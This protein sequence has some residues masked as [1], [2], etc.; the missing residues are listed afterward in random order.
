MKILMRLHLILL[1]GFILS[2]APS[3]AAAAPMGEDFVLANEYIA[4]TVNGSG[5]NT[6]RFSVNTTGGDPLRSDDDNKPLIYGRTNPWTSFTTVRVDSRDY[7]FGG[8]TFKR[9][10][11]GVPVGDRVKGPELVGDTIV[12]TYEMDRV[13]VTQTLGF[14]RSLTTG[15]KDTARI[16]YVIANRGNVERRVGLRV[17]LDT[18][19][20]ANDGAPFR[21]QEQSV[22]SDLS[23]LGQEVPQFWQAFDSLS[24][25]Q[26]TAQGTLKGNEL[27]PPDRIFFTNWGSVADAPWD[28]DFIP[29]RDFTRA[30]EFEL[31]SA[32]AL[33]WEPVTVGPGQ[34]VTY[35]SHYGMGGI[36]IAPGKL[37]LGV[38]APAQVVARTE[39]PEE[40]S[41]IAYVENSGEGKAL[42]V[43]AIIT[44]PNG[45]ELV[46]GSSVKT[47]GDIEVNA[48]A[49][50]RWQVR[51]VQPKIGMTEIGVQVEA[52][53]SESN[54]V[55]RRLEV[56]APARLV[57]DVE[58][59]EVPIN[60]TTWAPGAFKVKTRITNTGGA[61][62]RKVTAAFQSPIGIA[63]A[64]GEAERKFA[65]DL[66]P[67]QTEVVAWNLVPT[68]V[69]GNAI[70]Y[71]I[72]TV[73]TDTKDT[74]VN[75]TVA[76]PPSQSAIWWEWLTEP[77]A[78][79]TGNVL[80]GQLQVANLAEFTGGEAV[81]SF[82]PAVVQVVGGRLGVS[83]GTLMRFDAQENPVVSKWGQLVV[84]NKRGEIRFTVDLPTPLVRASGDWVEVGFKAVGSK[85]SVI[86][87]QLADI[88]A[89]NREEISVRSKNPFVVR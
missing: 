50:V 3:G 12:T 23:F 60:D 80:I 61:S 63:L 82:D 45:F 34:T 88:A 2:I 25:P 72:R 9:A 8:P 43:A 4:I 18:M 53:N 75:G 87:I 22:L 6:G 56:L 58:A 57:V 27:T 30:G 38:T 62:A 35:V 69:T 15:L 54:Q 28:F 83:Q 76:I 36:T 17:V 31:D 81:I 40:F 74:A 65:G 64:K 20:G 59:A 89:T 86:D 67:G 47:L 29:Q 51:A 55:S 84:D 73:S 85:S 46:D 48:S 42:D 71:T 32:M 41:V 70:P 78:M 10:G 24:L 14:A 33:M 26:V 1:A 13:Q 79:R 5:E 68:G 44:L 37:S 21:V 7:V 49:Q 52:K 77:A 39:S 11:Q 16:E 66:A 19:L